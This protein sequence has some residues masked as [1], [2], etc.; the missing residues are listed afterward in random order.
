[1]GTINLNSVSFGGNEATQG[2]GMYRAAGTTK[3][4]GTPGVAWN[5]DGFFEE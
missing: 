5:G 4:I 1:M 2:D 3:N